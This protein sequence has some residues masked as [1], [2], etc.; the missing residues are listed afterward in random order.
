MNGALDVTDFNR[1]GVHQQVVRG[2]FGGLGIYSQELQMRLVGIKTRSFGL[3]GVE[4]QIFLAFLNLQDAIGATERIHFN[5]HLFIWNLGQR[6][7][8]VLV[9]L[10]VL[11][12]S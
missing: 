6:V 4:F 9:S 7:L 2:G 1:L 10:G 11:V 3:R 12:L 8:P 5:I